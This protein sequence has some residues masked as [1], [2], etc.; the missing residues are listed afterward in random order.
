[1]RR[2]DAHHSG[3]LFEV[4]VA[5]GAGRS[6]DLILRMVPGFSKR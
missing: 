5:Y 6:L 3:P 4:S 1:M 2:R